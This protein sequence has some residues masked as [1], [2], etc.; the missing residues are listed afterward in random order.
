MFSTSEKIKALRQRQALTQGDLS[1]ERGM[2]RPTYA[3]REDGSTQWRLDEL[4]TLAKLFGV[5][6][7]ELIGD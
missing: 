2:T 4:E 7:T 3:S 6:V 5:Q 1:S